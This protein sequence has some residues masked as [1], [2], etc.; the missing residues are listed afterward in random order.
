MLLAFK[1]FK[2]VSNVFTDI[3]FACHFLISTPQ[4][5]TTYHTP[6]H[7]ALSKVAYRT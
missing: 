2:S 1:R 4:W 6:L 3:S 5:K 7:P